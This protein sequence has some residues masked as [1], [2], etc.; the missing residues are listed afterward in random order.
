[1]KTHFATVKRANES[2]NQNHWSNTLCVLEYT[3]ISLTDKIKEVN[4]K[5]CLDRHP[6]YKLSMQ[7]ALEANCF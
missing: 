7:A 5:T 4:C 6:K 1:M 3:E 2:D